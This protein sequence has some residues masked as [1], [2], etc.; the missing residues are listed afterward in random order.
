MCDAQK[1]VSLC[2]SRLEIIKFTNKTYACILYKLADK[3][4]LQYKDFK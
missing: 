3:V 1:D 2:S 4:L